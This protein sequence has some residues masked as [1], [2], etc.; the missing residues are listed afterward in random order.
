[1]VQVSP[2][3]RRVRQEFKAWAKMH[4]NFMTP[5]VRQII[6]VDDRVIEISEGIGFEHKDIFGVSVRKRVGE[7]KFEIERPN[8][9]ELFHN[10][11]EAL[12]YAEELKRKL[13]S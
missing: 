11:N 7:F 5:K 6:V 8:L 3:A 9:G 12:A 2:Y 1:M 10:F 4:P 13:E